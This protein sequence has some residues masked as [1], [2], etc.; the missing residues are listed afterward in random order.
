MSIW[1]TITGA[2]SSAYDATAEVASNIYD[3]GANAMSAAA[4]EFTL[5]LEE[6]KKNMAELIATQKEV[7]QRIETLGPGPDRDRLVAKR[8]ANRG[9]FTEYILP[10]YEKIAGYLDWP[11]DPTQMSGYEQTSYIKAGAM[12]FVP[13]AIGVAYAT[14]IAVVA[15]IVAVSVYLVNCV[16][17]ERE[18]LNDPALSAKEKYGMISK[19]GIFSNIGG[20]LGQAK[21]VVLGVAGIAVLYYGSKAFKK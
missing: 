10:A 12:G 14:Q 18:I 15:L 1:D 20:A 11:T 19:L 21:W 13:I 5:K 16:V 7:D 9:Y 17:T 3:A 2:T 6:F 4:D 8:D